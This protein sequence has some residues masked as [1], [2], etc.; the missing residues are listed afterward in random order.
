MDTKTLAD[1]I[2]KEIKNN[3]IHSLPAFDVGEMKDVLFEFNRIYEQAASKAYVSGVPSEVKFK[4]IRRVIGKLIRIHTDQ[5][6]E[7][8]YKIMKLIKM[9]Q[10]II[11]KKHGTASGV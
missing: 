6:S 2:I 9:Q 8:N 3:D 4:F 10:E 7:F 1:L 11:L 5:Q